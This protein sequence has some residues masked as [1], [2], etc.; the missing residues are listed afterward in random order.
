MIRGLIFSCALLLLGV[1]HSYAQSAYWTDIDAKSVIPEN[2]TED[3]YLPETYRAVEADLTVLRHQLRKA[4][5]ENTAAAATKK[6]FVS[7]PL[8]DGGS[9][10]FAAVESPVL[11]PGLA[12]RYPTI[13][14]YAAT[15]VNDPSLRARFGITDNGL[16]AIIE[17]AEGTVYIDPLWFG[18]TQYYRIYY[19]SDVDLSNLDLPVLS[20]GWSP[21]EHNESSGKEHLHPESE[22][23]F[24]GW[25]QSHQKT[26]QGEQVTLRVY[27]MALAC[28]SNFASTFG[29][30]LNSVM[31][32]FATCVNRLNEITMSE[33]AI[34]FELVENNDLLIF[35]TPSEDPYTTINVGSSL[36]GQNPVVINSFIP[37]SNYDIGHVF[38]GGCTDVGGVVSGVVCTDGKARG[39]TCHASANLI[40]TTD[41]IL[42]HEIAHQYAVSHSWSNCPSSMGQLA[43]G[44]AY[45]PGSG[46]TIMSYAGACG[47]QNIQFNPNIYYHARSIEQF[48]LFS[49][50][51]TGNTCATPI[52]VNNSDPNLTLPYSNGFFIPI[53]TPFELTA[54]AEDPDG[55]DL[56]YCW[57]QY[58]LGPVTELGS[59]TGNAPIFRSFPPIASPTRVFPR[60]PNIIANFTNNQEVLPTYT[61]DLTFRCT[62]RD[63]RPEGGGTVY[64]EVKFK[65]TE[66]AGPFLVTH[67]NATGL[68]FEGGKDV[69]ITWNV[70]NTD[71]NL[72]NCQ[73]VDIYLSTDGGNTYPTLLLS[74]TPNV[75]EAVV[76]MPLITSNTARIRVQAAENIFFDISDSNFSIQPPTEAG[77]TFNASSEVQQLICLPSEA[78]V[79]FATQSILDYESPITLEII[80]GLPA[81][82]VANFDSNPIQPGASS[83]LNFNF[84]DFDVL[85]D[86]LHVV[87]QATTSDLDTVLR[88]VVLRLFNNS[89]EALEILSPLPGASGVPIASTF[90][91]TEVPNADLYQWELATSPAFGNTVID[92]DMNLS[93]GFKA[94]EVV[95]EP[96]SLYY[97]RLRPV[98]VC[99][100]ADY[101][102]PYLFHTLTFSCDDY[103]SIDIPMPIPGGQLT[104]RTSE[105]PVFEDGIINKVNVVGLSGNYDFLSNIG[106]WL[107]SPTGTEVKLFSGICGNILNFNLDL[108]DESP[109]TIQCPP[110]TGQ[111]YKPQEPL[112]TFIGENTFGTWKLNVKVNSNFGNGGTLQN[113]GL[114]FCSSS[115]P[116]G[117]FVVNNDT[118]LVQ[119]GGWRVI[120]PE[121]LL[122]DDADNTP[123]QLTYTVVAA[124]KHGKIYWT[125]NE[126]PEGGTFRQLSINA[127]N[128]VYAH[129]G[130]QNE[131]D[132]FT[133]VVQDGTGGWV[134]IET[135]YIRIDEDAPVSTS[136]LPEDG[137][138][139]DV[140]IYPNPGS[141]LF[142]VELDRVLTDDL[143]LQL[144]SLDGK[145][146]YRTLIV[147][148]NQAASLNIGH[149]PDGMYVLHIRHA[150]GILTRKVQLI[151]P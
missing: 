3:L 20:C 19:P 29:G 1:G 77:F 63:Y 89:F 35:L 43:S 16:H 50:Q 143:D 71:N 86:T 122:V 60:L 121:K 148:G 61:R 119:P 99:G 69:T 74:S 72:V 24:Q 30:T 65:A 136:E 93:V 57:E 100:T 79:S 9:A 22:E 118:L 95:L 105:L 37:S 73:E 51:G 107:E 52:P 66:T 115:I 68:S 14:T 132:S 137:L 75:G 70:A 102:G 101:L 34:K 109:F 88:T 42:S 90:S 85:A 117:P 6:V 87:V 133:F 142:Q 150:Q 104:T 40:G 7:L 27:D 44:S 48:F 62:V 84:D 111:A 135:F 13:K 47:N 98:N 92:S 23:A 8:P 31:G 5:M 11:K 147:S 21:E 129:E 141:G 39:V 32:A 126:V 25:G 139:W 131:Y 49:R 134:G 26:T 146:V 125:G 114:Q 81:D 96:T 120:S 103:A 144:Y 41:R 15:G 55:D 59:P 64:D 4:P 108:D 82:V 33:V 113:W 58:D 106:V 54:V 123:E 138:S 83:T 94:P 110:T 46:S 149:L 127:S 45:E 36:L 56:T 80:D 112:A 53:S 91:W 38:T 67:P 28:T 145:P 124:P 97:W 130:D 128:V 18:Q 10:L 140:S 76:S 151:K 12:E 2:E 116:S 78:N 17:T